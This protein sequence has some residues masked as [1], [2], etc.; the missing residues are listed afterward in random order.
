[1]RSDSFVSSGP[2]T[3]RIST[4]RAANGCRTGS[5]PPALARFAMIIEN[6]PRETM[7]NP[8]FSEA[9]AESLALRPASIPAATLPTSVSSTAPS[10]GPYRPAQCEWV[11]SQ[12]ETEKEE[13]AEEVSERHDHML[14]PLAVLRISQDQSQEQRADRLGHM[15]SLAESGQQEQTGEDR[16]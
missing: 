13:R 1:M 2:S 10:A 14:D 6:S 9:K 3:A 16:Q 7:V 4:Y 12:S 8:V 11:D 15:D 5:S